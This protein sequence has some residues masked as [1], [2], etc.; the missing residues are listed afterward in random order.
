MVYKISDIP[1]YK[2]LINDEKNEQTKA[3]KLNKIIYSTKNNT[4]KVIRYDKNFL[5]FDTIPI[6]GLLRSVI[7]NSDNRVISFA[8][9]KSIPID[10]FIQNNEN[11]ENIIAEEFIEGTMINV[12]WDETSGLSGCWEIATRNTVGGDSSFYKSSF[13]KISKI[14][15]SFRDMFLEAVKENELDI[16]TLNQRFCYSFVLQHPDNRIVVPFKKPQLYLVEVY[17]IVN[18]ENGT[19]NVFP[20]PIQMYIGNGMFSKVKEQLNLNNTSIKFPTIYKDWTDYNDLRAKYASMNTPYEILGVVLR[21][22]STLSRSKIRNPVY[23]NVRQMRGNQPKLQYQYLSLRQQ[24]KVGEF[25]NFYPENKH[26][27]SFFRDN[28]HNFTLTLFQNYISCYI[29]KERPL[30]EFP[31]QYRTHMFHIHKNYIDELKPKNEYVNKTVVINYVN[32]MH[33]SLQ[34]YSLNHHMRK[35]HIDFVK[36]I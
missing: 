11:M 12:F 6:I 5:S 17:E 35:R 27:F 24:G 7:L 34:M 28:L 18:T 22:T 8:P 29:N 10:T 36:T 4:Y 3:L 23:E 2:E 14:S 32:N 19:V 20:I 26:E 16:N 33:P 25:L 21:N 13:S 31:D 30:K 9:P 1:G 15:K